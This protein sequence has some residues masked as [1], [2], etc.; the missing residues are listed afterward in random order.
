MESY[1]LREIRSQLP[2]GGIA[3]IADRMKIA[4]CVVSGI[5][6]HG[7]RGKYT[8]DVIMHSLELIKGKEPNLEVMKEARA[9]KL[10]SPY[11][12]IVHGSR[13]KGLWKKSINRSSRTGGIFGISIPVWIGIVAAAGI[14]LFLWFKNKAKG[15]A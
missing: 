15:G 10:T 9:M 4:P 5:L 13:K 2:L 1:N 3:D 6:N 14:G 11:A 12:S 7:R 8:N